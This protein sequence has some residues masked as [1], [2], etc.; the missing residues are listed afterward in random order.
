[1][2]DKYFFCY[3]RYVSDYLTEKGIKSITIAIDPKRK[4]MY[5]LYKQTDELS[6]ALTEYKL[7][8]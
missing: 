1:M 5:S 4:K 6:K 2:L 8:K 7:N 3:N